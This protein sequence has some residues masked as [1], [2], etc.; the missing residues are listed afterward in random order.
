MGGSKDEGKQEGRALEDERRKLD[1]NKEE[2]EED[3]R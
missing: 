2:E 3:E 1:D